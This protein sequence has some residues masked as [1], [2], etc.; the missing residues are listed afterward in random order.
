LGAGLC[1]AV[2]FAFVLNR[3]SAFAKLCMMW[4]LFSFLLLG[5]LGWGAGE[6][7][8]ALYSLYFFWAFFALLVMGLKKVQKNKPILCLALCVACVPLLFLNMQGLFHLVGFGMLYY[9]A[10]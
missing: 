10:Q 2:L 8:M 1:C 3:K 4:V 9:P 6:A 5:I 7:D